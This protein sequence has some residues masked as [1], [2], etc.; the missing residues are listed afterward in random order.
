M[1]NDIEI[2]VKG[3]N[4]F[5]RTA[6]AI[7]RSLG[8]IQLQA[9]KATAALGVAFST[10]TNL[11]GKA[12][13]ASASL[14]EQLTQ[15][16]AAGKRV[17]PAADG[18]DGVGASARRTS[19]ALKAL[20][21]ELAG[22]GAESDRVA[23]ALDKVKER[24]ADLIRQLDRTGDRELLPQ[25][26]NDQ[27]MITQLSKLAKTLTSVGQEAGGTIAKSLSQGIAAT[28]K[29]P[30]VL[31]A[32]AAIAA[33][34]APAIGAGLAGA[35]LG[36]AAAA[37]LTAGIA[38]A[39]RDQ[40]VARAIQA[41]SDRFSAELTAAGI[42][43]REPL[44]SAL[45]EIRGVLDDLDLA[46]MIAPLADVVEPVTDNLIEMVTRAGPGLREMFAASAPFI[47]QVSNALPIVGEALGELGKSL[48]DAGPGAAKFF[49]VFIEY[50]A[51]TIV[52]IGEVIEFLSKAYEWVAKFGEL[53]GLYDFGEESLTK[54]GETAPIAA[55]ALSQVA[56]TVEAVAQAE[57]DAKQATEDL[58]NAF[59]SAF[60]ASISFEEGLDNLK[61]SIDDNGRSLSVGSEKGRE[62]ISVFADL[63]DAAIAAG[64]AE[65]AAAIA[66]GDLTGASY[67]AAAAQN[68][69]ISK[70]LDQAAAM[71]YDR[72]QV[73][74]LI[75]RLLG[76]PTGTKTLN[77]Q[78][79][80]WHYIR[81]TGQDRQEQS[82]YGSGYAHAAGGW[83]R[84]GVNLVGEE[85][86]ELVWETKPRWVSTASETRQMMGTGGG[87]PV[88]AGG[89]GGQVVNIYISA[90]DRRTAAD[91][92]MDALD[93]WVRT[94]GPI[95]AKM[96]AA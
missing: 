3:D 28:A 14:A 48:A 5:T 79:N 35:G 8:S 19:P 85:G 38:G 37:A 22:A 56:Q 77:Y 33:S 60:D 65:R 92:V 58:Y 52:V 10:T 40:E 6:A 21:D 44:A 42:D 96:V 74:A 73:E 71:G 69:L 9:T 94:N 88:S 31:A 66:Q 78:I 86:P 11:A 23:K 15:L 76:L 54:I 82:R 59:R 34:L 57:R 36:A 24:H 27:A 87:M 32:G 43:F 30:Y 90:L 7:Q 75:N 1:A 50:G 25:I 95:P 93:Q 20:G 17:K 45:H 63:V 68:A 13:D 2:H 46:G 49:Q 80:E 26:K 84:P 67:R 61:A 53:I 4:D 47:D 12:E 51:G 18:V 89:G 72:N 81:Y 62:N 83:T 16:G 64:E 55:G 70:I 91:G 41:V 39:A 29:S